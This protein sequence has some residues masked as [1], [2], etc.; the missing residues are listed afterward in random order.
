VKA[1][2]R[3]SK[4]SASSRRQRREQRRKLRW[5]GFNVQA[6]TILFAVLLH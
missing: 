6:G 4:K 2:A 3:S 5:I 1:A